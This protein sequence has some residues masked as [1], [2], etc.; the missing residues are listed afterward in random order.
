MINI[1][2]RI[3]QYIAPAIYRY[4]VVKQELDNKGYVLT[5]SLISAHSTEL[6]AEHAITTM[7]RVYQAG[8]CLKNG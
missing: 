7:K 1:R 2:F 4:C 6:K 5:E 8:V 3:Q